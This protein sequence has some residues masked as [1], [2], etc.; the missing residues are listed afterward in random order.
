MFSEITLNILTL[1]VS[2]KIGILILEEKTVFTRFS[3]MMMMLKFVEHNWNNN[4][5]E[6]RFTKFAIGWPKFK[7]QI[8]PPKNLWPR[9]SW[10]L[11]WWWF[12]GN[13]KSLVFLSFAIPWK[14]FLKKAPKYPTSFSFHQV[15]FCSIYYFTWWRCIL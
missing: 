9:N 2:W 4:F 6:K 11:V 10:M 14:K 13:F 8:A 7:F 5:R 3:F 1:I 15:L 12:L